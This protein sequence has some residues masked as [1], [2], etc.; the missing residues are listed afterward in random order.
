[1]IRL[2]LALEDLLKPKLL[3][4]LDFQDRKVLESD[5][6]RRGGSNLS[7]FLST[8]GKLKARILFF[9]RTT[10]PSY[11]I[12]SSTVQ[13]ITRRSR[14]NRRGRGGGGGQVQV[15]STPL[16]RRER[17]RERL[18]QG[19]GWSGWTEGRRKQIGRKRY[20]FHTKAVKRIEVN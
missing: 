15:S 8:Q 2:L 6:T 12:K 3:L 14:G 13:V 1:M 10:N 9:F 11:V 18:R 20:P 16:A 17:E 7:A 19:S 5:E 4:K